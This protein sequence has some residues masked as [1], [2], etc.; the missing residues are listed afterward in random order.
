MGLGI[1][2][3][4]RKLKNRGARSQRRRRID[5]Q[6]CARTNVSIDDYVSLHYGLNRAERRALKK[7]Q[8]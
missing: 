8:R 5:S 6:L 2:N 4:S 3:G 7:S 1:S